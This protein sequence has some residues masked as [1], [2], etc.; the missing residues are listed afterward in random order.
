MTPLL[1]KEGWMLMAL[2]SADGVV[3]FT[4]SSYSRRGVLNFLTS[5]I[6]F[7]S[8]R[9]LINLAHFTNFLLF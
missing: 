3:R 8:R 2:Q 5:Q 9:E 1:G 7:Y 4:F 6:P